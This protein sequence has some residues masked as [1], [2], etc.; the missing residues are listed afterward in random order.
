V[1]YAREELNLEVIHGDI[2]SIERGERFDAITAWNFIEHL[3]DPLGFLRTAHDLLSDRGVLALTTPNIN[4]LRVQLKGLGTWDLLTPPEHIHLFSRKSLR[5][6]LGKTGFSVSSMVTS[7]DDWLYRRRT[8]GF[9][10]RSLL[11]LSGFLG[12]GGGIFVL[13]EKVSETET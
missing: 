8:K 7:H 10:L 4:C 1:R 12:L 13:S 9:F 11:R 2:T 6:A 5:L 3:Q